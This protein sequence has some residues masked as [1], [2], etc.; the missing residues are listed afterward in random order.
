MPLT[1][2]PNLTLRLVFLGLLDWDFFFFE[3]RF[4]VYNFNEFENLEY[5]LSILCEF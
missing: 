4:R 3:P 1:Y 2:Q 5:N